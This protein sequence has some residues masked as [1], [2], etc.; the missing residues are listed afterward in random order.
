MTG[1]S[2]FGRTLSLVCLLVM[3]V[4]SPSSAYELFDLGAAV[5]PQDINN[6]GLIVGSYINAQGQQNAFRFAIAS[7][8]LVALDGTAAYAVN[9]AGQIAGN[10]LVG[11]FRQEGNKRRSWD[12]VSAYGLNA[13]GE[14]AGAQVGF[15]IYRPWPLPY[16]PAVYDGKKWTAPDIAQ[17]YPRG[18]RLG[19][20]ADIYLLADINDNG[21][22]VGSRRRYGLAGSSAL[23]IAPPYGAVR[24]AADLTY[25]PTSGGAAAA[26]SNNNL[27]VGTTGAGEAFLYDGSVVTLLGTL[28]GGSYS[29]ATDINDSGTVVGSSATASGD[30]AFIK[31]FG[32]AMQDLNDLANAPQWVLVTAHAINELGDIVGTGLLNGQPHGFLLTNGGAAPVVQQP[33]PAVSTPTEPAP[34]TSVVTASQPPIA[35]ATAENTSGKIPLEVNFKGEQSYDPDGS[36]LNFHWDFGDTTFSTETNPKHVYKRTGSFL[37]VLTV[38]DQDNLSAQSVPIEI[39]SSTKK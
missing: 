17:V 6:T 11:A 9:D 24:T 25:L 18:S 34:A 7:G 29:S 23:M 12:G 15:N 28:P 31:P 2:N 13:N 32:A 5:V 33:P 30:H 1:K 39:A 22:A 19:V 35:V 20:Y 27:I 10:T 36:P 3:L 14:I 16:N 8:Q 4:C 26:I 37:A 21:V 38:T